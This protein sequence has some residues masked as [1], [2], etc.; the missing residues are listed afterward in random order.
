MTHTAQAS[1]QLARHITRSASRQTDLTVSFLVDRPRVEDAYRAY[2]Y[3]RWVDDYLDHPGSPPDDCRHFL[4]RQ[5]RLLEL[6]YAGKAFPTTAEEQMLLD[7]VAPGSDPEDGL[8]RYLHS[9][10]DVMAFDVH[11]RGRPV[12]EAELSRYT[13]ALAVAVTEVL[14]YFIGHDSPSPMSPARYQAVRGA[15]IAHMLRDL[16]EDLLNGYINIPTEVLDGRH[17]QT[18]DPRAPWFVEWVR[19]RVAE[20]RACLLDGKGYFQE[21]ESR[22][23]RIAARAYMLRFEDALR[24]I[25]RADFIL[26]PR[27]IPAGRASSTI[28]RAA[29]AGLRRSGSRPGRPPSTAPVIPPPRPTS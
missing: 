9:M 5:V 3:F 29:L 10:M 21:A 7:L 14:H 16:P 15:H 20:A 22:R 23:C 12:S 2:A 11:R 17:V 19:R 26:D 13:Y 28:L 8:G 25:E 18:L 4:D 24:A 6:A 1:A 27:T